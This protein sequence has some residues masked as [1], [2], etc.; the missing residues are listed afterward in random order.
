[1][2]LL[3]SRPDGSLTS[4]PGPR[5]AA[6]SG[7]RL[8]PLRAADLVPLP[9]GATLAHLPGRVA[10]GLQGGEAVEI[11]GMLPVAAVLPV[12]HL[13]TL[14]PASRPLRGAPRLPLF[15]YTAV[16][17][18][19]G[20]PMVAAVRTDDLEWWNPARFRSPDLPAAVEAARRALPG[21]RVVEQLAVCAL[22][23]NCYTA[24]NTMHRRYEGALPASPACNADCLGCISLQSDGEAPTPQ[25]R[26]RYAPTAAELA[27]LA[28]WHLG[29]DDA[30]IVSFGQGCEGEPLTRPDALEEATRMIRS[31]H[32]E[33]TIHINTNGSSPAALRR[34]VGAGCNSVRISAISFDDRVFRPYYRPVGYSLD[35]VLECGEVMRAAGGQ[36]CLNLLTFPGVTDSPGE[37][38]RTVAACRRMGVSQVQWR[39]L[40][41]D[42]DWLAAVL[43]ELEPGIGLAAAL[44][45][46]RGSLAGVEHGNFTR[47]VAPI[48]AP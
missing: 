25:P 28:T 15:G 7:R 36:V 21:N 2:R 30:R 23:H 42:H 41:V 32:P 35:E 33:A 43:P 27:D 37:L 13:R 47:P 31:R 10:I 17:E 22:E 11:P 26:M 5:P 40:N 39:S 38:E 3:L 16:A 48:A 9:E 45:T 44:E 24:Q 19:G 8:V 14:C 6:R 46:M 34:L 1:M 20:E 18:H 4:L 29:G 12:G